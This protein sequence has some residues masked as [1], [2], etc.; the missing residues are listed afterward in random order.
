MAEV[1]TTQHSFFSE[2]LAQHG[3]VF[4]IQKIHTGVPGGPLVLQVIGTVI[5][6]GQVIARFEDC[7]EGRVMFGLTCWLFGF[8]TGVQAAS[9][10]P[11]QVPEST[12]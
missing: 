12:N 6:D 2:K 10:Q 5:R 3:L 9:A 7:D 4:N 11:I 8:D 1:E